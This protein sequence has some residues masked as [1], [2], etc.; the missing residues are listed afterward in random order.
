M[1]DKLKTL[2]DKIFKDGVEKAEAEKAPFW[3]KHK[4]KRRALSKLPRTPAKQK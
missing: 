1:E 4:K 2:T 3:K